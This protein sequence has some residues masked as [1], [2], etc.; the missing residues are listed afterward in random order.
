MP[1]T[2]GYL[3]ALTIRLATGASRLPEETRSRHARYLKAAQQPDGG[4]TGRL[5]TSNLY[6]TSFAIRS[7]AILGELYGEV[8]ERTTAY[9]RSRLSRR[10][11]V[12]DRISLVFSAAMLDVAAGID[13]FAEWS[14]QWR[15][16]LATE[17]AG[18]RRADGGFAKT[19]QGAAGSTYQT[20]LAV[21]CLQ[22]MDRP[23]ADPE[24]IVRF[25][26]SQR[27]EQGG[28]FREIR[29]G[30]RA[31]TNPTAAAIGILKTFNALDGELV[32]S[33]AECLADLQD[34]DGGLLAHSRIPTADALSTFTGAA[35]LADL[36]RLDVLDIPSALRFTHSVERP[37]GGFRA[38][39]WDD[40][41][42]VEYTFYGLGSLALLTPTAS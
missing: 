1:T 16:S 41:C 24:G 21:L 11:P 8:A 15:D 34:D 6:Y 2:P 19:P 7:L 12:V 10:D 23:V 17:L 39:A 26:H 22:L 18:L 42:D 14:G 40:V 4:F 31:G 20:F 9:L 5:G 27:A 38:A 30:K 13:V 32:A 25:V 3:E 29:A 28:G 36:G 33:T 37:S 35:T